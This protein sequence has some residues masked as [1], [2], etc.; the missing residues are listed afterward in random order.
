MLEEMLALCSDDDEFQE[1]YHS[2]L[3]LPNVHTCQ[4]LHTYKPS[5]WTSSSPTLT[6][7]ELLAMK[8]NNREQFDLTIQRIFMAKVDR[9]REIQRIFL[10]KVDRMREKQKKEEKGEKK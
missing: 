8:Q 1:L 7:S 4:S 2:N 9:D 3:T 5:T 10:E 6:R